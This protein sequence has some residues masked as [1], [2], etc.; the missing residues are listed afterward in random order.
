MKVGIVILN[1]LVYQDT[2]AFVKTIKQQHQEDVA[3]KIVIVD[4]GS[5]NESAEVLRKEY[6][7][8]AQVSVVVAEKNLGFAGGNNLG[9]FALRKEMNPDYV[10]VANDDILLQE[11]GLFDWIERED[12]AHPFGVLGPKVYSQNGN[13]YQSPMPP[14]SQDVKECE[15]NL[16]RMQWTLLE[17]MVKN[18]IKKL[19]KRDDQN[20]LLPKWTELDYQTLS[21]TQTLHGAFLVFSKRYLAHFTA[22]FDPETFLYMEENILRIRCQKEQMLMLYSP[23]YEVVH[24]QATATQKQNKSRLDLRYF[25]TKHKIKSMKRY[26]ALLKEFERTALATNGEKEPVGATRN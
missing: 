5:N 13:Y 21:T 11:Q 19:L 26:I 9:Y 8:D 18:P 4:N 17:M 7:A 25:Q 6:K 14:C 23:N 15:R 3:V 12:A 22:P 2:I 24:L 10:I 20:F 16:L 1:Y